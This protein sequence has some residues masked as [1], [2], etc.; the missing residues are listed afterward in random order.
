M[1]V[2]CYRWGLCKRTVVYNDFKR[3]MINA[4][5]KSS[6]QFVDNN[7]FFPCRIAYRYTACT[8]FNA[9]RDCVLESVAVCTRLSFSLVIEYGERRLILAPEWTANCA[10]VSKKL[11]FCICFQ[12]NEWAKSISTSLPPPFSILKRCRP[13]LI[14]GQRRSL[15]GIARWEEAIDIFQSDFSNSALRL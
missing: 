4:I 15:N 6:Q 8:A 11:I 2:W 12:S 5:F 1:T 9:F 10:S 3:L 14:S 7:W 13:G